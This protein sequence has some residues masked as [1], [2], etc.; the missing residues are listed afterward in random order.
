MLK[1]VMLVTLTGTIAVHKSMKAL[2]IKTGGADAEL[3]MNN[4][5]LHC[6]KVTGKQKEQVLDTVPQETA[7]ETAC[8]DKR[9]SERPR[10][11]KRPD[12]LPHVDLRETACCRAE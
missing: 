11:D 7:Q 9:P 8:V 2:P 4:E 1:M 6:H 12:H 5:T 10:V 3:A